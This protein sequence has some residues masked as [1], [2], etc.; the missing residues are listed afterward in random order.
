MSLIAAG[1]L[2]HEGKILLGQRALGGDLPLF[3][4]F[5][6]GKVEVGESPS[7]TL[8]RECREELGI[9]IQI[10]PLLWQTA[11]PYPKKMVHLFFYAAQP[12]LG[13]PQANVQ[14][15]LRWVLPEELLQ[16]PLCPA[17][18]PFAKAL[19][20]GELKIPFMPTR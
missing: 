9:T 8:Q 10:G 16:Y 3:W 4:E 5:P 6:G 18:L 20:A 13:K 7:K 2:F 19:T 17:N 1:L 12:V 15:A 11:Y 14:I